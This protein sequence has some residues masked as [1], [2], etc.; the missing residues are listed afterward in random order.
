M[1]KQKFLEW[2]FGGSD[3]ERQE[4]LANIGKWVEQSLQINGESYLSVEMLIESS[5]IE[6]FN[7]DT[8]DFV[9]LVT[10]MTSNESDVIDVVKELNELFDGE[11]FKYQKWIDDAVFRVYGRIE[12]SKIEDTDILNEFVE[13]SPDVNFIEI[14]K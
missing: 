2:Y 5:D 1:D 4:T 3:Q 12:K 7:E 10:Y 8:K 13:T 9:G 11:Y 6:V 14:K